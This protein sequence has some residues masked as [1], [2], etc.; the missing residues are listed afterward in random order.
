MIFVRIRHLDIVVAFLFQ[1]C[2][3]T[4]F[5]DFTDIGRRKPTGIGYAGLK[6]A[7]GIS[8]RRNIA[9]G[10]ENAVAI[11]IEG[12]ATGVLS[13]LFASLQTRVGFGFALSAGGTAVLEL[14]DIANVS[15]GSVSLLG[16]PDPGFPG[17]FL[18]AESMTPF[19]RAEVSFKVADGKW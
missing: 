6:G 17:G 18:G 14:F 3:L 13:L 12:N 8:S 16:V 4:L 10:R 5:P 15:L 2:V 1:Q 7:S 11:D 19:A 9:T